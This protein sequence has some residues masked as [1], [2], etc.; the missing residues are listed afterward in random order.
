MREDLTASAPAVQE[1]KAVLADDPGVGN[2]SEE[3][4]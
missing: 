1:T 4:A 2:T 3:V